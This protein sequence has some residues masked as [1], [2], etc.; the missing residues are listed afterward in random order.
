MRLTPPRFLLAA[1]GASLLAAGCGSSS[2]PSS[3]WPYPATGSYAGSA[4]SGDP[5]S[6]AFRM[7]VLASSEY[8]I[9]FGDYNANE[10]VMRGFVAGTNVTAQPWATGA[11]YRAAG[12]VLNTNMSTQYDANTGN[13]S[14]SLTTSSNTSHDFAGIYY[15]QA[16]LTVD[17]DW[18]NARD[19]NGQLM[20]LR[21]ASNGAI[22]ATTASSCVFFGSWRFSQ[23]VAN[24]LLIDLDD[25]G[26]GCLDPRARTTYSGVAFREYTFGSNRS[27]LIVT[28]LNG[29]R[30]IGVGLTAVR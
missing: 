17:G 8:W 9:P 1:L 5:G 14:G 30:S 2:E 15:T 28:A 29:A 21:F 25:T 19:L 6:N 7:A 13:L 12:L 20:T 18:V 4:F 16:G 22:S 3:I 24:L 23:S 26:S 11:M 27:Q 10:F